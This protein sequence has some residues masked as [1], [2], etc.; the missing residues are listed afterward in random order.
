LSDK[1][2]IELLALRLVPDIGN[3]LCRRLIEYFGSAGEVLR[4]DQNEWKEVSR[5]G[6]HIP[7]NL[8]AHSLLRRA[9]QELELIWKHKVSVTS[10]FDD[11]YPTRLRGTY[12]APCV[13]FYRGDLTSLEGKN[14]GVVGTRRATPYG[15]R[16]VEQLM[17][18]LNE[19]G[20]CIV[21]GLAYGID[22][23]AHRSALD[24]DMKTVAVLAHGLDRVY[25]SAHMMDA[26]EMV[27]KGGAI[28]SEYI[29]GVGPDRENFPSRNRI[30]AGLSDALLV[31]EAMEKGGALITADIAFSYNK[32]V[33]AVPGKTEDLCS[34]GCNN[35]IKYNKARIF[36]NA[37]DI[38]KEM[39]WDE[40]Q[41]PKK[42]A[43]LSMRLFSE[44]EQKV[45]DILDQKGAM[46]IDKI[47][48]VLGCSSIVLPGTLLGLELEGVIRNL[49]GNRYVLI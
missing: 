38:L 41:L 32:E 23:A 13:L 14:L 7:F 44:D 19:T 36:S 37:Q 1:E 12:D 47:A 8:N 45:I 20:I 42:K 27:E 15:Y 9:E 34:V 16:S 10:I 46:D 40:E 43:Q 28:L 5:I 2:I 25:P 49:P 24:Q 11:A 33:F 22:I 18:D 30:I 29:I 17:D 48:S 4:A 6:N 39:G 3:V 31:V 21:S 35:L 26:N